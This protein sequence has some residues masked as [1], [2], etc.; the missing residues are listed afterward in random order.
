[1]TGKKGPKAEN[2]RLKA[3][4]DQALDG[5]KLLLKEVKQLRLSGWRGFK[6]HLQNPE[7]LLSAEP[8]IKGIYSRGGKD[9]VK[10]WLD[11]DYREELEFRNNEENLSLRQE[12]LDLKLFKALG[13][14]IPLGGHLMVSYE[15]ENNI[16][17]ETRQ[18]LSFNIPPAVTPI[19]YLIFKAGFQLIKDWYLAE[20]GFEGPRKLWGE[21]APDE[22]WEKIFLERTSDQISHFLEKKSDLIPQE[23]EDT[24]LKNSQD[25]IQIIQGRK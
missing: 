24:A 12:Y 6:L 14:I 1:M 18:S 16:H 9:G 11:V 5:Y 8:V 17:K 23:L 2:E 19:G 20:G 13:T 15:G 7:G 3:L 4:H 10:P 21:K 25:I 22:R